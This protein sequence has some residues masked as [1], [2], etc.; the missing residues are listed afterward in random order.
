MPVNIHN[1][2]CPAL[3]QLHKLVLLDGIYS[4]MGMEII[5]NFRSHSRQLCL[6][7]LPPFQVILVL[8]SNIS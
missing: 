1:F 5:G 6:V 4:N 3:G 7:A 8:L 2:F